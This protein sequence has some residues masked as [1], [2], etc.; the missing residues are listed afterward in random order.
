[1]N[2]ASLT[3][4]LA[5]VETGS[6]VGASQ[7]LNVTQSTITARLKALE[8]DLGQTLIVR[9]KSGATLTGAGEKLRRYADV[10]TQLW[11]Q[12]RQETSLPDR[13]KL[14]CNIGCHHDLWDGL[15]REFFEQLRKLHGNAAV[16]AWPAGQRGLRDWMSAGLIDV[17][18]DYHLSETGNLRFYALPKDRLILV[19]TDSNAPIEHNPSYVFI[20]AGDDFGRQHAADFAGKGSA[21]L[22]FGSARWGL[23]HILKHGGSGYFA[24]RMVT[25]HLASGQLHHLS[26]APVYTRNVYLSVTE[27][28]AREWDWLEA[29]IAQLNGMDKMPMVL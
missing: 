22:S 21:N 6:L 3:T 8:Q 11:S 25:Q 27:R 29:V 7:K 16:S 9:H 14:V 4:F 10:M 23:E 13:I 20:E 28:V 12:A 26:Q 15:G 19:S 17:S 5:I 18:I 2:L 1:M 24:E